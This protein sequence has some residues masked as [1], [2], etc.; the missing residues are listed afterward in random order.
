MYFIVEM[1]Q[2]GKI[3]LGIIG[4][5]CMSKKLKMFRTGRMYNI[6]IFIKS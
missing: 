4:I 1:K 6:R 3:G 2:I 5:G